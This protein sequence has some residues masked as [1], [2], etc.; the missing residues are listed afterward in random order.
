MEVFVLAS[1]LSV[2][3]TKT[4][5]SQSLKQSITWTGSFCF[6]LTAPVP[7]L[8]W[9]LLDKDVLILGATC[10]HVTVPTAV[11]ASL[12]PLPFHRQGSHCFSPVTTS[13]GVAVLQILIFLMFKMA[14]NIVLKIS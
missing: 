4:K 13:G 2:L 8:M 1:V 6:P 11:P 5:T 12:V 9:H 7:C 3:R 10:T 14:H